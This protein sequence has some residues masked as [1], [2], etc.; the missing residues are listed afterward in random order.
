LRRGNLALV[1]NELKGLPVRVIRGADRRSDFAPKSG[2]RYDGLYRVETHWHEIGRDGFKVWRYRLV[3][4]D[5][6]NTVLP[7]SGTQ[8]A[9][10]LTGGNLTPSRGNLIV[11]RVVRD[12][13]QAKQLK[14][15]YEYSYQVC[16]IYIETPTGR[17]A[18]AAHI[19]PLGEPHNGPDTPDN[20]LCLCP[21]HH[22]MFDVG[23][24]SI[25]DD[26]SLVGIVG[27][28]HVMDGHHLSTQHLQYHRA[29]YLN[30]TK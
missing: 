16:G 19:R 1:V 27:H 23:S 14:Q 8:T 24:F 11:Q 7:N 3:K 4:L 2:Y 30:M 12:T 29:H 22:V 13:K 5:N 26:L 6:E 21:N 25:E 9:Q 17:Y 10:V 28:L 15:L 20:I 18:E